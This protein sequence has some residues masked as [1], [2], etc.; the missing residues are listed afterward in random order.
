MLE[1][2]II[3]KSLFSAILLYFVVNSIWRFHIYNNLFTSI[4]VFLM[5]IVFI[6][7][8]DLAYNLLFLLLVIGLT[9]ITA[10][11]YLYFK[12]KKIE[13]YWLINIGRHDYHRVRYYLQLNAPENLN[14]RYNKKTFFVLKLSH[15]EKPV[16]KKIMKGFEVAES[17]R[18]TR[19]TICN[20]WQI[21]IFITMMVILWRF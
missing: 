17:K 1:F 4:Y 5:L 11:V 13:Y 14:Y 9:V 16:V 12:Q 3:L 2:N 8:S 15:N 18:K 10:G 20:Y 19:F 7:Y 21:I 6:I